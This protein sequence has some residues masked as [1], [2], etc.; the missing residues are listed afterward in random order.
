MAGYVPRAELVFE[1]EAICSPPQ[2]MGV[3]DGGKARMIPIIGGTVSGPKLQGEVIPGGADWS[4]MRGNGVATVDARY[5]LQ[6]SDGTIIQIFNGVTD[7]MAPR[8]DRGGVMALTSPRF[9]AP[10][11]PHE[12]LNH[13]VFVGTLAPVIAPDRFAV[14]IAIYQLV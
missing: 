10:E 14:A 8:E 3:I 7:H 6:A 2:D 13:G 12:W 9:I 11:G 4:I 1:I 5:A